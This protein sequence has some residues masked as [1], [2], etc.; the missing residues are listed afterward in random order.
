M[1]QELRQSTATI[2]E[3]GPLVDKTDGVVLEEAITVTNLTVS[4]FKQID[5]LPADIITNGAFGSDTGWTKGTNWRIASGVAD[6]STPTASDLEQTPSTA[7]VEGQAYEVVYTTLNRTVG[8][9]VVKVGGTSGTSRTTNATFTEIIVAGSG[10]LIEFRQELDPDFWVPPV[11]GPMMIKKVMRQGGRR[12]ILRVE[13]YARIAAG[14]SAE[15][16]P[17]LKRK[18]KRRSDHGQ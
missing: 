4:M 2:I 17:P 16:P 3:V 7:L 9:I 13:Y 1:V 12:A 8:A 18:R 11:F 14:L 6:Q 5:V 10:T 15:E